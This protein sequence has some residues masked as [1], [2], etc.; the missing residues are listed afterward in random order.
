MGKNF[1]NRAFMGVQKLEVVNYETIEF[2]QI[3][4]S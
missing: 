4:F 1:S 3:E 2:L